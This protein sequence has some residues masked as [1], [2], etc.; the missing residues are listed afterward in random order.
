MNDPGFNV[1][2]KSKF[3]AYEIANNPK[4][5]QNNKMIPENFNIGCILYTN[6]ISFYKG[7][8]FVLFYVLFTRMII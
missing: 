4:N 1:D 3:D 5:K 8:V 6:I 2:P 7:I